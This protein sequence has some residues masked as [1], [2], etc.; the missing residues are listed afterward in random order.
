M[1][2]GDEPSTAGSQDLPASASS[3]DACSKPTRGR[4]TDSE[5]EG[6]S[7]VEATSAPK[8]F[9]F[10]DSGGD[11]RQT[12]LVVESLNPSKPLDTTE[13]EGVG[14]A[15]AVGSSNSSLLA[16]DKPFNYYT[17]SNPCP[18]VVQ[19]IPVVISDRDAK[20]K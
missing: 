20:S 10:D 17:V 16:R 14:S 13:T 11:D 1:L 2:G 6:N 12:E 19:I 9:R 7:S 18:G 4:G 15:S 8:V 5:C 3:S